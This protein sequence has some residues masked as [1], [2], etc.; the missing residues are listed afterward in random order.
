[1]AKKKRKTMAELAEGHKEFMKGKEENPNGL[2]LFER[3]LKNAIPKP[4]KKPRGS[5]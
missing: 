5:K 1:M 4:V 2:A 3:A